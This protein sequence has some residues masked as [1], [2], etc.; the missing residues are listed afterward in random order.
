MSAHQPSAIVFRLINETTLFVSSCVERR[1]ANPHSLLRLQSPYCCPSTHP[2]IQPFKLSRSNSYGVFFFF[3]CASATTQVKPT[4]TTADFTISFE[5]DHFTIRDF[6]TT[7]IGGHPI[8]FILMQ[9]ELDE[10]VV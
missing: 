2:I 6:H 10:F 9:C 3:S 8:K 5:F 1:S 7:V 4:I